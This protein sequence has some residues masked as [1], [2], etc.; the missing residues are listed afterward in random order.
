[1]ES[2]NPCIA[3][4]WTEEPASDVFR[5][6]AARINVRPEDFDAHA[7]VHGFQ[8]DPSTPV[9]NVD[10]FDPIDI[11]DSL[12]FSFRHGDAAFEDFNET[13]DESW[14]QDDHALWVSV[15]RGLAQQH[16]EVKLNNNSFIRN[17]DML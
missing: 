11:W 6:T 13:L 2:M 15:S 3:S 8:A 9:V 4:G 16:I 14:E 17:P 5:R 12:V 7:F 10:T 1:M